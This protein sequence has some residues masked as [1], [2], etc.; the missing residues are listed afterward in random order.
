VPSEDGFVLIEILVSALVLVIASAGVVALLQTTVHTQAA[1]RHA[2]EAYSLAQEDQARL[3]T[4]RVEQLWALDETRTIT[5]NQTQFTVHSTGNAI[6]DIT[7]APSCGEGTYKV[8]YV[9]VTSAVT[10][11]GM[12]NAEKARIVSKLA[13]SKGSLSPTKGSLAVSVTNQAQAPMPG[14]SFYGGSGA[15]NGS[16]DATGCAI[17][18][19]LPEGNYSVTVSGEAAGLVNKEGKGSELATLPVA[20]GDTRRSAFEFDHPGTIPVEFKYR[21]GSEE[22]FLTSSADSVVV[23]NT[24]MK[25]ARIFG[26]PGGTR[27]TT[28]E[29]TPLYPFSSAYTI[30]AGSC[31]SNNPAPEGKGENAA[32]VANV[33][34]PAGAKATPV[35]LQLPA[36]D[37]TVWSGK[38][39]ANKGSPLANADVWVRDPKCT[40]GGQPV[41]RRY[42]TNSLGKLTDLGLP[43]GTY[44]VCA[45]TEPGTKTSGVRRQRIENV[46][47]KEL[48]A[49]TT[50]D[51]Y[52]G[53]GSGSKSEEGSCP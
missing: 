36:F 25:Q 47:V 52:L 49:G 15:I 10:W 45:D 50:R 42:T 16:T 1:E 11:P 7:S 39:E 31:A 30:Y 17:F 32:A 22:K 53:S 13:P 12:S 24:G 27:L 21:V 6:N 8:D 14:V 33:V 43:F 29:A 20:G 40:Q 51:F 2:S 5:L 35:A 9:Q 46:S 44:T 19:N 34:V 38:N 23:N 48:K 18:P 28:V 37:P 3:A 41:T 4:M 26:T